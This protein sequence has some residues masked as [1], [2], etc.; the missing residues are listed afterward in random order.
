MPGVP[1]DLAAAVAVVTGGG[2][3]IGRATALALARRGTRV[4]VAD[5][6][7]ARA[8]AVAAELGDQ[9]VGLR[10]DVTSTEDVEAAR[11]VA[12]ERFGRV[13]VL[14]NNVGYPV[15][16]LPE[17]IPLDAWQRL[18]DVNLLGVVRGIRAFVPH[19]VAQG[20][21]HV[22]NTA[23]IAGLFPYAFGHERLPY[24][25]TKYAVVGISE[26][27]A[28]YL[29]PKGVGVSCLCPATVR[30]NI[31]EQVQAY[32]DVQPKAPAFPHADVDEV[33]ELVAAAIEEDRFLVLT[34]TGVAEEMRE[35]AADVDAFLRRITAETITA[36]GSARSTRVARRPGAGTSP[37]RPP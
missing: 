24:V 11:D 6:D 13:D 28:I 29:R 9:A 23:S 22:V 14:M 20:S 19:L 7:G 33:G 8:D 34:T 5:L 3:G 25:A 31:A 4:V 18:I 1:V 17:D 36:R 32:G 16:G 26:Q 2:S 27:L 15:V 12:L 35:H 30:T 10:C 21:G 37:S